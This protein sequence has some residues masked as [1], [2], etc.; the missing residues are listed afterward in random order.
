MAGKE[1][2]SFRSEV[3]RQYGIL[4]I[5]KQPQDVD[6]QLSDLFVD[7]VSC[8]EE[9]RETAIKKLEVRWKKSLAQ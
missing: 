1:I 8:D 9:S 6:D 5:S 3:A 2:K 7:L 4:L